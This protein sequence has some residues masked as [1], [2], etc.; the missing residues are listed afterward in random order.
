[1]T[2][3]ASPY[4]NGL[5]FTILGLSRKGMHWKLVAYSFVF[6]AYDQNFTVMKKKKSRL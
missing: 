5:G 1:L 6:K 2:V 4:Q 3:F